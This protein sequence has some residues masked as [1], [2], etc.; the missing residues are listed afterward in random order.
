MPIAAHRLALQG[1]P[2][3]LVPLDWAETQNDLGLA[4]TSPDERLV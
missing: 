3:E 1:E 2:R 4:W